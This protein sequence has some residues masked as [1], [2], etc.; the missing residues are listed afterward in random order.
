MH[1]FRRHPPS[2]PRL[3]TRGLEHTWLH[4]YILA[5]LI[6]RQLRVIWALEHETIVQIATVVHSIEYDKQHTL[7]LTLDGKQ[8]T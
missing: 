7:A 1:S 8:V 2:P 3:E 4:T 6:D 5:R